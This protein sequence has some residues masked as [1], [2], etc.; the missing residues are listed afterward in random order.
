MLDELLITIE[1]QIETATTLLRDVMAL[2]N[3]TAVERYDIAR[4]VKTY[5][6]GLAQL[7]DRLS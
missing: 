1:S 2:T 4:L 7:N 5:L 6:D 3:A